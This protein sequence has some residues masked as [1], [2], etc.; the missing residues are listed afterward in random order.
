MKPEG[1]DIKIKHFEGIFHQYSRNLLL[2]AL[3]YLP[4]REEVED[5]V[6]EVFLN[7]WKT[8]AFD[9][10]KGEALKTY[11]FRSV[12]NNCLNRLEKKDVMRNGVDLLYDSVAEE[13]AGALNEELIRQIQDTIETM[14]P[15]TREI[16]KLIFWKG[17]KYREAADALG[18]S[19]NTVKTLLKNG[20]RHLRDRFGGR[21]DLF[22]AAILIP[23]Q[24]EQGESLF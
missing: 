9:L 2:Y 13:E 4:A 7:F 22:L 14:A 1:L 23:V 10:L 5:V 21:A 15:Q 8:D 16:I 24:T 20:I 12:R 17:M 18:I 11:L 3:H 19:V 6:Q